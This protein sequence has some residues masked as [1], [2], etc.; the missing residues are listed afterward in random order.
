MLLI[1]LACRLGGTSAQAQVATV[2]IEKHGTFNGTGAYW[3]QE[4]TIS[5]QSAFV[6]R[7]TTDY[8]ADAAVVTGAQL[9]NFTSNQPFS[10]YALFDNQYGT[11]SVTLPPGTYYVAVR[12]QS[13]S[14]SNYRME[15]DHD[16]TVPP[17][18]TRTYTFI[19]NYI[20]G[21]EYVN[22]NGGK[23]WHGFTIQSGVRYFLD[24]C[25]TGLS[26]YVIPAS[27][28]A[29][30]QSGGTFNYY[31]AYSG[32][33]NAYPGLSEITLAPGSYYLAFINSNG[34]RKPVTY[35]MERW[36]VNEIATGGAIDLSGTAS[37]SAKNGKV[38][39][40]VGKIANLATSG[41]SGSLRLR[42]WVVKSKF[43][44][45]KLVGHILGTQTLKPLS[46]G[47]QYTKIKAK[48]PFAKPPSGR[49]YSVL[50]L[51][52]LTT[53]GWKIRDYIGFANTIQL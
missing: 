38:T 26:T 41:K 27:E 12:S 35:T 28:L 20:Q 50:T 36:R 30:F 16:I 19:D 44:G 17:D 9:G 21:T 11:K 32:T 1:L 52:E 25:N 3:Y 22:A 29:A 47:K 42:V 8:A 45:G 4:F 6:L 5:Q 2:F 40:K 46:A 18:A 10:G 15:L 7:V 48:V 53:T 51:E 39:M 34:I 49:Y 24:G 33:D 13:S 37:W 23:L 31:T 14:V 43:S